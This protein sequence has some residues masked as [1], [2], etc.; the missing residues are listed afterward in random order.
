M[1]IKKIIIKKSTIFAYIF[2]RALPQIIFGTLFVSGLAQSACLGD[3]NSTRSFTVAVVPQ[4][5][6]AATYAKWAPLLEAI[7]RNTKQCF[8]LQVP[9]TIPAFEKLLLKGEPDFAFVNPYHEVMAKKRRGYIPLVMDSRSKLTGI[10][11]VQ[12]N[13]PIKSIQELKGKEIAFPAPNAF[14]ASLLIRAELAKKGIYIKPKYL[15]T[16]ASSYRAAAIGDVVAS[17]GVNTT[18]LREETALRE[19]LRVLY[20]TTGYAPHPFVANPRVPIN[21]RKS[22][23]DAFI[24]LSGTESGDKLLE[25]I[26]MPIPMRSDYQRDYA[27]LESLNLEKFVVLDEG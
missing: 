21:I 8:D 22:V 17:G 26:Q 6:R 9:E 4:L 14:A 7:G 10:L 20:E 11:V 15:N 27:P 25:G 13:S 5:P 19:S 3:Q 18:L 16:H 12:V 23:T 2:Y 24:A 1:K